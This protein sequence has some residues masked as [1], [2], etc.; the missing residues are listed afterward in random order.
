MPEVHGDFV[1]ASF[2]E[3]S[4]FFHRYSDIVEYCRSCSYNPD[5]GGSIALCFIRRFFAAGD[6]G[7]RGPACQ[8][9]PSACKL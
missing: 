3:E 1:F 4:G 9:S 7:Q 5:N 6:A 2:V 8:H